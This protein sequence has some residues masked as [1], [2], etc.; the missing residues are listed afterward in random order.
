[1][2]VSYMLESLKKNTDLNKHLG[3]M[4]R[5]VKR[6]TVRPVWYW[7]KVLIKE[8]MLVTIQKK[9]FHTLRKAVVTEM[10]KVV[11]IWV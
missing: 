1:M 3:I 10:L 2:A 5:V 7:D 11:E 6:I 8:I 9:Q 4:N